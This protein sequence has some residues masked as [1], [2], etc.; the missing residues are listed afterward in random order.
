MI[1]AH[2][3]T[4]GL[5]LVTNNERHFKRVAGLKVVSWF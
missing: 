1:A 4:L 3:V 5:T 2:A